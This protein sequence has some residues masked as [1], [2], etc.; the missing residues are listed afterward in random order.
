MNKQINYTEL[1]SDL[2][3]V[4][5]DY[6]NLNYFEPVSLSERLA[7][8]KTLPNS[9]YFL[10]NIALVEQSV[11]I[12]SRGMIEYIKQTS[13]HFQPVR[14]KSYFSD[15]HDC[16]LLDRCPVFHLLLALRELP[17]EMHL[18]EELGAI[19]CALAI[20]EGKQALLSLSDIDSR[21]LKRPMRVREAIQWVELNL[22]NYFSRELMFRDVDLIAKFIPPLD[23]QM[24]LYPQGEM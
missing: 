2:S 9:V 13:K 12:V 3:T 21:K 4:S 10:N 22:T 18:P 15:L 8:A 1:F 16:P 5:E 7:I 20:R 14:P 19:L 17:E 6:L 24:I 23:S 11:K